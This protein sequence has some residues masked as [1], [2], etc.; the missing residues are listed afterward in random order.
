MMRRREVL[1]PDSELHF[2]ASTNVPEPFHVFWKVRNKGDVARRND[3]IRGQIIQTNKLSHKETTSFKGNHYVECYI[4]KDG[5]CVAKERIN[6][7]I[8]FS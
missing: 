5:E 3:M 8:K 6:V 7:E 2:Q 4:V 1:Y